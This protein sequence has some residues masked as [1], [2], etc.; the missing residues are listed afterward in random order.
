VT[1]PRLAWAQR[2]GARVHMVIEDTR[3]YEQR[4]ACGQHIV[5]LDE[6]AEYEEATLGLFWCRRC[7]PQWARYREGD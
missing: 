5:Q 7:R 2:R 1:V 3:P 4:T 6:V